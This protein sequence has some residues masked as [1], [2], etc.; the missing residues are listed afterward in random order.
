MQ[1]L[2]GI[3][4]FDYNSLFSVLEVV[5]AILGA[6]LVVIELRKS[7]NAAS[8]E[9]VL[10]LQE[11]FASSEGFAELFDKC[12][13]YH[14]GKL[15]D[16]KL[17]EHL[18]AHREILLNY[19][20][21]FESVYL[22]KKRKTIKM[23][24]LDELFGRRFLSVTNNRIVQEV[25]LVKNHDYYTNIFYLYSDWKKYRLRNGNNELFLTNKQGEIDKR[26]CDLEEAYLSREK[27]DD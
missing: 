21:F 5:V 15:S 4:S 19:L 23:E 10:N 9:F 12:W 24:L 20:T 2:M 27:N 6:I 16:D 1:L 3:V 13:K 26:Y 17:I 14:E 18:Q 11:Q 7:G 22:M 25:D 8:G